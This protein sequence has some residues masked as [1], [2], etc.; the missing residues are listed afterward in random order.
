MS[1]EEIIRAWKDEEARA[2]LLTNAQ[3]NP[4]G[5]VDLTDEALD[6]LIAGNM[7]DDSCCWESCKP[8]QHY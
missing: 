4:A 7:A 2:S 1:A 5:L 8:R 3:P 6:G